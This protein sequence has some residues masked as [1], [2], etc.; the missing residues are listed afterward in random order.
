MKRA[1]A[2]LLE[3]AQLKI[4]GDR[5]ATVHLNLSYR[6]T[7]YFA[8]ALAC[9]ACM[10]NR[11]AAST[12]P[13]SQPE[14]PSTWVDAQ[15]RVCG[16]IRG[17]IILQRTG[18]PLEG[19]FITIDGTRAMTR[20]DESGVFQMRR[21]AS[22]PLPAILRVR[23]IGMEPVLIELGDPVDGRGYVIE[24]AVVSGGFHADDYSVVTVR[25]PTCQRAS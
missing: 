25:R 6:R 2:H 3:C 20:N 1:R 24:I 14:L 21:E 5:W 11:P 7:R 17:R 13:A 9:S 22:H 16:D 4:I 23:R 19:A 18:Q 12:V 10:G 15:P 8:A